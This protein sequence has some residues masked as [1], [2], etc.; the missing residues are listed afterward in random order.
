[1]HQ[2]YCAASPRLVFTL[3]GLVCSIPS[4]S[5]P[6]SSCQP[7][8]SLHPPRPIR[9][10]P[11]PHK[12]TSNP[13][14]TLGDEPGRSRTVAPAA[15]THKHRSN[16]AERPLL[17]FG[18]PLGFRTDCDLAPATPRPRR[19][20]SRTQ[21]SKLLTTPTHCSLRDSFSQTALSSLCDR[22]L[23]H[24]RPSDDAASNGYR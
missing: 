5:S 13:S 20:P 23:C 19:V 1:M 17:R 16:P 8:S 11:P 9:H 22:T 15:R 12:L 6:L 7:H 2:S 18:R 24:L 4:M 14:I 21:P 10:D 3:P